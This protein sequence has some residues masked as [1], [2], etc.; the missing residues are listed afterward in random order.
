MTNHADSTADSR[1]D[2]RRLWV[3]LGVLAVVVALPLVA[4]ALGRRYT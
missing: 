4:A 3:V 2:K 1:R